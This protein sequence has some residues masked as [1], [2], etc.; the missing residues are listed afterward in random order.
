MNLELR[1]RIADCIIIG[2]GVSGL[3]CAHS[4]AKEHQG[5]I[6]VLEAQDYVGT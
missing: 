2:G 1:S 5:E 6:L 4:L 3:K